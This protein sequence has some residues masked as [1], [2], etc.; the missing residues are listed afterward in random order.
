[1]NTQTLTGYSEQLEKLDLTA[2][3]GKSGIPRRTLERIRG[4]VDYPMSITTRLA[5]DAALKKFAA[6]CQKKGLGA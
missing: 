3:S 4:S 1:M 6:R 5:L 2:L